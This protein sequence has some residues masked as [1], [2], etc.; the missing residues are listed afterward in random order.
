MLRRVDLVEG[1]DGS[2]PLRKEIADACG[3]LLL[4]TRVT[5]VPVTPQ[6]ACW[7]QG[8][9]RAASVVGAWIRPS[10]AGACECESP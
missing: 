8:D 9:G 6:I 1:F 4:H 2:G 10:R 5:A 3:L 7:V